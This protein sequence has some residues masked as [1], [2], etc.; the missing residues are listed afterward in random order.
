MNKEELLNMSITQLK[1]KIEELNNNLN[2]L[3]EKKEQAFLMTQPKA[4]QLKEICV[5]GGTRENLYDKYVIKNEQL[6][7]AIEFVQDEIKLLEDYLNRELERI[8]KYDEWEQKVIYL[9]DTGKTW[10]YIACNTP[11]S[12]RTCQRIYK[13]Y[14]GKRTIEKD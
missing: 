7:P 11:F 13:N 6:D 4:R 14:T 8:N 12:I 10:L 3:L 1:S 9:R 5:V 2:Y